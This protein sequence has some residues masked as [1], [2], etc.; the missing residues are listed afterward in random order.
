MIANIANIA[1]YR[2]NIFSNDPALQVRSTQQFRRLLSIGSFFYFLHI[3][4]VIDRNLFPIEKNP[5]IQQVIEAGVIAR[6]VEF[7]RQ[8]ENPVRFWFIAS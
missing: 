1:E 3:L 7:L 2:N 5:P 8:H 4:V 6:F